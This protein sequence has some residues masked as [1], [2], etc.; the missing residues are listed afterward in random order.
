MPLTK[1][2]GSCSSKERRNDDGEVAGVEL[3]FGGGVK[4]GAG[5]QG[6]GLSPQLWPLVSESL[7]SG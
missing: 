5:R 1:K 2:T 3:P 7:L 6:Q 4:W